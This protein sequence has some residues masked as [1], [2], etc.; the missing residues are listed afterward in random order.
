MTTARVSRRNDAIVSIGSTAYAET[1]SCESTV[2]PGEVTGWAAY[3]AG[4]VWALPPESGAGLDI[5][6]HSDIPLGAGLASSAALECAVASAVNEELGLGLDPPALASA[7][8]RAENEFVGVP[9]GVMDQLASLLC[10]VGQALLID[11]RTLTHSDVRLE[12]SGQDLRLLIVDSAVRHEL[13][14]SAYARRRAE[15]DAAA[16]ALG[17]GSL[18]D[19]TL[20]DVDV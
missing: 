9:T 3:V 16:T 12:L 17:V 10:Q 13:A 6:V 5:Q 14:A 20:A 1:V 19:A 2:Q 7:C 11:C 8:Q 15:C 4:V 18:R